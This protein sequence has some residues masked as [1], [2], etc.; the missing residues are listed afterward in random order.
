MRRNLFLRA[1]TLAT[2]VA[3]FT[4]TASAYYYYVLYNGRSAPFTPIFEKFDVNAL[5][6]KT[7]LFYISDSNPAPLASGDSMPAVVS[8]IRSAADVWNHVAS[9]DLRIAYGG[10]YTAGNDAAIKS[11]ISVE[12][13]DNVPPGLLAMSTP[14][15]VGTVSIGPNGPFVPIT[16]STMQIARDIF[17]RGAVPASW[18]DL[19]FTTMVHEFGHTIGLQH[20]LTSAVMA[21]AYTSAA[22]KAIPLAE[23]DIAAV[24]ALYPT[25]TYLLG[26]G[27]ISGRV[28]LNTSGSPGVTLASVVAISPSNPAIGTI[29][30]PDGTYR[31][32]G[33]PPGMYTVYVHPLPPAR[34]G[35][36]AP[37]N[38]V[39][40]VDLNGLPFPLPSTAFDT[41]FYGNTQDYSQATYIAVSPSNVTSGINFSVRPRAAVG[42]NSVRTYGYSASNL[43]IMPPAVTLGTNATTNV[44]ADGSGLLV[45][46]TSLI[47]GL[48]VSVLGTSSLG[49]FYG[50]LPYFGTALLYFESGSGGYPGLKHLVFTSPN[51]LYILP[52]G[53]NM[54]AGPPPSI[55]SALPS[56]DSSGTRIVAV[57]GTG[58]LPDTRILLDGLPAPTVGTSPDGNTIF[59]APPQG[60]GSYQA[61]VTALNSDGQSSTYLQASPP[62]YTY[63]PAGP[64]TLQV[65]PA[66]LVS[67]DNIVTIQGTN[68]NF[69]DGQVFVGFGSSDVVVK[70]VTIV[71]PTLLNVSVTL[72]STAFVPTTSINITAGLQLISQDFGVSI[73][74]APPQ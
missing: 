41:Q 24:S 27:S 5:P 55:A 21:T 72:N 56:Q 74:V 71:S 65:S 20:T 29:T 51:D 67:G 52:A 35:E 25:G 43:A 37:A 53:I 58:F 7:V 28:T 47:P 19:F 2:V 13:S 36:T 3:G 70:K 31:I 22:T 14:D 40:P 62:L 57:T 11:G 63:D 50:M 6:N 34:Q 38:L 66:V 69:V 33:V 18:S 4:G 32:D 44:V 73:S 17:S 42:I 68:T 26:T 1:L 61:I 16:H 12:F 45:N 59:V 23:D 8:E 60:A 15:S 10:L 48:N 54:V 46:G 9:S 30:N 39:L 64:P 49:Q